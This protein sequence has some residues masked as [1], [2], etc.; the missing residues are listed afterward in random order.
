MFIPD[1]DPLSGSSGSWFFTHPGSWIQGSKGTGARIA[2][3]G[4]KKASDPG[5]GS[6]T[7]LS[8]TALPT[9][10]V[11]QYL[12]PLNTACNVF[13]RASRVPG[14]TPVREG[15]REDLLGAPVFQ[16]AGDI[17][18]AHQV[19]TFFIRSPRV[20]TCV[21]D[22]WHVWDGSGSGS[23]DPCLFT[24]V[25]GSWIRILLFSSLTFKMT[26]KN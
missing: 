8:I 4:V 12:Q 1:P 21:A 2:D 3:P 16:A 13:F 25:S 14:G 11:Y 17:P 6:A 7:L 5:S 23:A 22:P 18:R 15:G 19:Y 10:S 9:L 26:A 20:F 24:N